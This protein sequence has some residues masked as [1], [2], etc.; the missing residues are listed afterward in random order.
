M[1]RLRLGKAD[2]FS[3]FGNQYA[4]NNS[5]HT[6]DGPNT[7]LISLDAVRPKSAAFSFGGG[8]LHPPRATDHE[9][10]SRPRT[11][12]LTH[13]IRGGLTRPATLECNIGPADYSVDQHSIARNVKQPRPGRS[14]F[15]T[16][17]RFARPG[18]VFVSAEHAKA[19]GTVCSPGPKYAY[20]QGSVSVKARQ[21][22]SLSW[23]P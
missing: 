14:G 20:S 23:V 2:R 8:R 15:G 3:S 18:L 19:D 6:S 4:L 17:P 9:A 22:T 16:A 21:S 1:A 10:R 5:P 7:A 13:S 12:F 11:A